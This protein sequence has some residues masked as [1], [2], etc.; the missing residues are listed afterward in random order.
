MRG[1]VVTSPVV[2][3]QLRLNASAFSLIEIVLAL[4]VISFALV[5][6]MG[7]FPA[8][9]KSAKESQEETRATHIAQ[10]IFDDLVTLSGT[11]GFLA[12]GTNIVESGSRQTVSLTT[13]GTYLVS[14]DAAGRP[15]GGG[16]VS[17]AAFLATIGITTNTPASGLSRVQATIQ[18]P[19]TAANALR[20][21]YT[22]V[23]V[24]N[25]GG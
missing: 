23:T 15:V 25:P 8:A 24:L 17:G 10:Q 16:A 20:S 13:S 3:S 1:S 11:N 12:I 5:G 18:T 2:P 6:I 21:S 4:A 7:L 22:F 19:P 9:M 14:Y